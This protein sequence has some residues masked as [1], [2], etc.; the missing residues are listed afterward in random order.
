MN[1]PKYVHNPVLREWVNKI[2]E[3]C[4]PDHVYWCDGS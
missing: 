1:F 2:V 3:L 4:E